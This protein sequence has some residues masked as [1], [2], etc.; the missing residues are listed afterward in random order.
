MA[1]TGSQSMLSVLFMLTTFFYNLTVAQDELQDQHKYRAEF[2]ILGARQ[3]TT[4]PSKLRP[5][6]SAT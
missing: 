2:G 4:C 1:K 6:V 5:S 3:D